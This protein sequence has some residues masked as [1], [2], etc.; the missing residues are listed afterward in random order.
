MKTTGSSRIDFGYLITASV[1]K[2]HDFGD[3]RIHSL[4]IL[5][6]VFLQYVGDA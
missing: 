2:K 3:I 5:K 6:P 1:Y 4:G